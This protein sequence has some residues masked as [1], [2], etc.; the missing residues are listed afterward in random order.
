MSSAAL[1]DIEA[2]I[3]AHVDAYLGFTTSGMRSGVLAMLEEP[4]PQGLHVG[5][6]ASINW[7][8]KLMLDQMKL[9]MQ[10]VFERKTTRCHPPG[11]EDFS[12]R[13]GKLHN[14]IIIGAIR[15]RPRCTWKAFT[16]FLL[17]KRRA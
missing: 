10:F 13:V 2:T 6:M 5:F 4:H 14:P 3:K 9:P 1:H 7:L 12:K 17:R 15:T 8:N 11:A 16:H